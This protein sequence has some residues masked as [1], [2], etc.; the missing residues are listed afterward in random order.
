MLSKE[1]RLDVDPACFDVV[2][3]FTDGDFNCVGITFEFQT[4]L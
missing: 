2:L 1:N 3:I 4:N